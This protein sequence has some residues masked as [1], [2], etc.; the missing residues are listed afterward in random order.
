MFFNKMRE[1]QVCNG[2]LN[3]EVLKPT[4]S[5]RELEER[6]LNLYSDI[7]PINC[8]GRCIGLQCTEVNLSVLNSL[9]QHG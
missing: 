7:G 5:N 2:I 9:R 8:S 1:M 4:F 6:Y 3:D